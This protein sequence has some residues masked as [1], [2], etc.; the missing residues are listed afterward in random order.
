MVSCKGISKAYDNQVV[1]EKFNFQFEDMG[2]Y[3]LFGESGSGKT[4]LLNILA[5]HIPYDEGEINFYGQKYTGQLDAYKVGGH[6]EYITQDA[7]FID[8]LTVYDNL[9]LCC[10]DDKLIDEYL[11]KFDL[12]DKKNQYPAKLSGGEKQR[13]CF[14]RALIQNKRV[15]L[16]DE[17]TASLD[18]EN[19]KLVFE[20][21]KMLKDSV[22][23]ICSSHDEE[24]KE[25]ADVCVD[26]NNLETYTDSDTSEVEISNI[27]EENVIIKKKIGPYMRKWFSSP[28]K[29]KGSKY[30]FAIIII[31]ALL[32]LWLGDTPQ[33]K[34][35][36]SIEYMYG[37][38]QLEMKVNRKDM[39]IVE[40][41]YQ[42]DDIKEIVLEYTGSVML[43]YYDYYGEIQEY[44]Y[45]KGINVLPVDKDLI[46]TDDFLECGRY[47]ENKNEIIA[48]YKLGVDSCDPES[49]LGQT[50]K[51]NVLGS[52]REMTIVGVFKE[53][54]KIQAEYFYNSGISQEGSTIDYTMSAAVMEDFKDN[55]DLYNDEY[56]NFTLYFDSYSDMKKFYDNENGKQGDIKFEFP[57]MQVGSEV[58]F[59]TLNRY[60]IP[61]SITA[62]L[63]AV[64][65]YYQTQQ[66]EIMYNRKMFVV[67]QYLGYAIWKVK[68]TWIIGN[69]LDLFKISIVSGVIA[70]VVAFISNMINRTYKIIY[71]EI[72][73]FDVEVL[74]S[75]LGAILIIGVSN[76]LLMMRKLKIESI[77]K[78][79]VGQRDLL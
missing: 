79:L 75:L 44:E 5:G 43:F 70:Y 21:L 62:M 4:T 47:I 71:F 68:L 67:Y 26:F 30:R 36:S 1:L 74:L 8:Y 16:L 76:A 64:I 11:E 34:M 14:V 63:M 15:L 23:I 55:K 12:L 10:N 57:E 65:F 3:L 52:I 40:T 18:G 25:Y 61:I 53:F 22:L 58:I 72:F 66:T 37:V 48:S 28:F 35:A 24:A 27:L 33:N 59:Y 78:N 73:T 54:N 46:K 42:R 39:D 13:I 38:N 45:E 17:P 51:L 56:R 20:T 31:L 29:D 50:V 32:G 9:S 19:K 7:N 60:M 49:L 69:I 77:N 41:F 2:F 6:I